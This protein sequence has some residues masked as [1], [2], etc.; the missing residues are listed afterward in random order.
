[1]DPQFDDE[2]SP[3]SRLLPAPEQEE[4]LSQ[5]R[6]ESVS[7]LNKH[8]CQRVEMQVSQEVKN[9]TNVVEKAMEVSD[10]LC[11]QVEEAIQVEEQV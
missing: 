5:Q 6:E 9:P 4:N 2:E 8:Q 7:L 1:M 11:L 3:D 10:N